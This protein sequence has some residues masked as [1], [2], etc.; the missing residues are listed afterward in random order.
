MNVDTPWRKQATFNLSDL[1]LISGT[2]TLTNVLSNVKTLR[3]LSAASGPAWRGDSLEA[4][5]TVDNISAVPLPGALWLFSTVS[6]SLAGYQKH[7]KT[8]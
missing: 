6:L 1:V 5:L 4:Y 8:S 2:E 7:N 3:I